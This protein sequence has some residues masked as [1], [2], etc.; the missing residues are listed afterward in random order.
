MEHYQRLEA[1]Y[2]RLEEYLRFWSSRREMQRSSQRNQISGPHCWW[3]W[4]TLESIKDWSNLQGTCSS[5]HHQFALIPGYCEL[6]FKT[7]KIDTHVQFVWSS[8][9]QHSFE[10]I[11]EIL[12]SDLLLTHYDTKQEII[13]AADASKSVIG[14]VAMLPERWLKLKPVT[15]KLKKKV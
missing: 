2:K 15:A 13:I 10:K 12:Q 11:K 1:L 7:G 3:K 9:C 14:A 6:I 4:T 5:Q 8:A